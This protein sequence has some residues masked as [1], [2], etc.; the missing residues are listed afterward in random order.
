MVAFQSLDKYVFDNRGISPVPNVLL[1]NMFS[2]I[3]QVQ[4]LIFAGPVVN[5][6]ILGL[7]FVWLAVEAASPP[8]P[9]LCPPFHQDFFPYLGFFLLWEWQEYWIAL[10]ADQMLWKCQS[11][12]STREWGWEAG[13][14]QP[15]LS[16]LNSHSV[17]L[18]NLVDAF[19]CPVEDPAVGELPC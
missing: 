1:P 2:Q 8:W 3:S 9:Y 15:P 7:S 19:D 18:F 11:Q 4:Q 12:I 5:F 17:I 13:R 6:C 14:P 16:P 10:S